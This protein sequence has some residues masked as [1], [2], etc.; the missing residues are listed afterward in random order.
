M[1]DLTLENKL[2]FHFEKMKEFCIK[3]LT[4]DSYK[5]V[6]FIIV[7]NKNQ[8]V[9]LIHCNLDKETSFV[10]GN[11][12]NELFK[13]KFVLVVTKK[14][15]TIKLTAIDLILR[16][17]YFLEIEIKENE[18]I[19]TYTSKN[20]TLTLQN[21]LQKNDEKYDTINLLK[22]GFYSNLTENLS[23]MN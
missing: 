5:N 17:E 22:K 20:D 13:P 18:L 10:Q 3:E 21:F 8:E 2:E 6:C 16:T 23:L 1:I 12:L 19:K 9:D 4:K 15:K 11:I 14:E 7:P